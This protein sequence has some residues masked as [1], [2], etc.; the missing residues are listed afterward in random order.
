MRDKFEEKRLVLDEKARDEMGEE[1]A[2][3][4]KE[5]QRK[6]KILKLKSKFKILNS[7]EI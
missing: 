1:L 4:I 2:Y 3:K 5:L 7:K 6:K